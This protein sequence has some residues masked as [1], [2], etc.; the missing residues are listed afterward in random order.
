MS[1]SAS[2]RCLNCGAPL[3]GAYCSA[4]GQQSRDPRP[5]VSDIAGDFASEMLQ[6]DGKLVRTFRMLLTRPGALTL[7]YVEGRRARFLS[8]V[9]VYLL[10]SALFFFFNA[11]MPAPAV[12]HGSDGRVQ[13]G[14]MDGMTVGLLG[15]PADTNSV[16]S[17]QG[18]DIP[19]TRARS[20]AR[21]RAD[22]A[23]FQQRVESAAPQVMFVLLPF[24][25]LLIAA[26]FSGPGLHYPQHLIFTLHL[27]AVFFLAFAAQMLVAGLL[28]SRASGALLITGI[29][30]SVGYLAR[31]AQRVYARGTVSTLARA[32][33]VASGY[34][35]LWI[36]AL[37]ASIAIIAATY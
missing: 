34:T 10:C 19:E 12:P 36:A 4:C 3:S 29:L 6:W 11:V 28:P 23:G 25:A 22:R 8:P 17:A 2:S 9:K 31:S 5:T 20:F 27:Q 18:A 24:T 21:V 7:E 33:V 26:A 14:I 32:A 16:A 37:S 15:G 13:S 1:P 30:A 35:L